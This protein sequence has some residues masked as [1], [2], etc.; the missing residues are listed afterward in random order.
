MNF[1]NISLLGCLLGH[2]VL[3]FQ[4]SNL[5]N[6]DLWLFVF[7][8]LSHKMAQRCKNML[9]WCR[10]FC[11]KIYVMAN[12]VIF[13]IGGCWIK[14]LFIVWRVS[15]RVWCQWIICRGYIRVSKVHFKKNCNRKFHGKIDIQVRFLTFSFIC[16]SILKGWEWIGKSKLVSEVN[17]NMV[18]GVQVW[19]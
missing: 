5:F 15:I 3:I 6:E 10:I 8:I 11:L 7:W 17:L 2:L 13:Y 9:S 12:C 19:K 18:F 1:L 4:L 14:C 16:G